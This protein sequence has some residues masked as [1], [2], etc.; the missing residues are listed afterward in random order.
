MER[1]E[2]EKP[3]V[4]PAS[5]NLNP[6]RGHLANVFAWG[7][8]AVKVYPLAKNP[9]G[10]DWQHLPPEAASNHTDGLPVYAKAER[11]IS[12][13]QD[14]N[15]EGE[16]YNYGLKPK[17]DTSSSV[18]IFDVDKGEGEQAP[19]KAAVPE[20]FKTYRVRNEHDGRFHAYFTIKPSDTPCLPDGFSKG[21]MQIYGRNPGIQILGPGSVCRYDAKKPPKGK[22]ERVILPG[23]ILPLPDSL[24]AAVAKN[25]AH[26]GQSEHEHEEPKR[27][28]TRASGKRKKTLL[29]LGKAL[30]RLPDERCDIRDLWF[31]V[32]L[33]VNGAYNAGLFQPEITEYEILSVLTEWSER[34]ANYTDGCVPERWRTIKDDKPEDQTLSWQSLEYWA[35][36]RKARAEDAQPERKPWDDYLSCLREA[37]PATEQTMAARLLVEWPDEFVLVTDGYAKN[38]L[39]YRITE[40]GLLTNEDDLTTQLL[41]TTIKRAQHDVLEE[42]R[43]DTTKGWL[44]GLSIALAR[45]DNKWPAIQAKALVAHSTLLALGYPKDRLPRRKHPNDTDKNPRYLGVK[46]GVLDIHT[47]EILDRQAAVREYVTG[48]ARTLWWPGRRHPVVDKVFPPFEAI[49]AI[50]DPR[51]RKN[52]CDIAAVYGWMFCHYPN[53]SLVAEVGETGTGKTTRRRLLKSALGSYVGEVS[54]ELMAGNQHGGE[55]INSG[56]RVFGPP[57]RYVFMAEMKR[58]QINTPRLNQM[59]SEPFF[60]LRQH[61]QEARE[62][63]ITAH[64]IMQGNPSER[65]TIGLAGEGDTA[66][67]LR[68]RIRCLTQILPTEADPTIK[69][70][71]LSSIV[72]RA[73][74]CRMVEYA[75]RVKD[76]KTMPRSVD[77]EEWLTKLEGDETPEWA[78]V[79]LGDI[80]SECRHTRYGTKTPLQSYVVFRVIR[81]QLQAAGVIQRYWP[82]EKVMLSYMQAGLRKR[83]PSAPRRDL[84]GVDRRYRATIKGDWDSHLKTYREKV[85]RGRTKEWENIEWDG[86][87]A[88]QATYD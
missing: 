59:T 61:Y 84:E 88:S 44:I 23:D 67:A 70:L 68:R 38:T 21:D 65:G 54:A 17:T 29:E 81:Q 6:I 41:Y 83:F 34:S 27:K 56:M 35:E 58:A 26:S 64:L 42:W 13:L 60:P 69:D 16:H 74:L 18:I 20:L 2:L 9:I 3:S 36:Q 19:L 10:D 31:E 76:L 32:L 14:T 78:K 86:L 30:N 87:E 52:A 66:K 25:G 63:R 46:N 28:K 43:A 4:K 45:F 82:S 5:D 85:V 39:L 11:V 47:G 62:C 79:Y 50:S 7:L 49:E 75:Q 51:R 73:V 72:K 33:A 12:W 77:M 37:D 24:N 48:Q 1:I 53:D 71:A 15:D 8:E 57:Y 80:L 55:Q 22:Y 40:K